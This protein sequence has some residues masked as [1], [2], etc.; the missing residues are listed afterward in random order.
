MRSGGGA[1][2]DTGGVSAPDRRCGLLPIR[3]GFRV[4][5]T[6]CSVSFGEIDEARDERCARQTDLETQRYVVEVPETRRHQFLLSAVVTERFGVSSWKI[7]GRESRRQ[8][9]S[10]AAVVRSRSSAART[11]AESV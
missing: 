8:A 7:L 10:V 4:I 2:G 5:A 11:A 1:S 3:S 6:P 9:E